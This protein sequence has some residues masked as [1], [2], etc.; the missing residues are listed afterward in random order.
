MVSYV[1]VWGCFLLTREFVYPSSTTRV[2]TALYS[3][4]DFRSVALLI[5][6]CCY[7]N[8]SLTLIRL[9]ISRCSAFAPAQRSLARSWRAP[10]CLP[11]HRKNHIVRTIFNQRIISSHIHSNYTKSPNQH[12]FQQS[13]F[14]IWNQQWQRRPS[15]TRQSSF[16]SRIF[17]QP[18]RN[19]NMPRILRFHECRESH[20]QFLRRQQLFNLQIRADPAHQELRA[21]FQ[22]VTMEWLPNFSSI[23]SSN[24]TRINMCNNKVR[25]LALNCSVLYLY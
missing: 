25:L 9:S 8:Y 6:M 14:Q 21:P 23:Y 24:S 7:S 11:H 17:Q 3:E 1:G 19:F 15:S 18:S 20:R 13:F 12:F 4:S 16:Q 5:W 2:W 10:S 22:K